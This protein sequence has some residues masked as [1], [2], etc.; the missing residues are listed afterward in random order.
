MT[1]ESTMQRL[2]QVTPATMRER[3]R[4][5]TAALHTEVERCLDITARLRSVSSYANLV[6]TLFGYHEPLERTAAG[7]PTPEPPLGFSPWGCA[8]L[9]ARDLRALRPCSDVAGV[10]RCTRLPAL[11]RPEHVAG[12]LYVVEGSALGGQ[13][14]AREGRRH[15]GLSGDCVAFFTGTGAETGLRWRR[16]VAWLD[17]VTSAGA[18]ADEIVHGARDTF[19]T[20]IAWLDDETR[21]T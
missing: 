8:A 1:T 17:E 21:A 20:L 14:I 4:A 6:A 11:D 10:R 18:D 2:P 15:R 19:G 13:E 7:A 16:V 5:E 12:C 9:L 3:L